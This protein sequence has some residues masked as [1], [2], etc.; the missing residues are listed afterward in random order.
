MATSGQNSTTELDDID[1][2]NQ[3]KRLALVQIK[4]AYQLAEQ[5]LLSGEPVDLILLDCP[6]FLGRDMAP[7]KDAPEHTE[8]RKTYDDTLAVI[9]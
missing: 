2:V 1:F 8:Y 3:S 5:R 7:L 9:Y 4:Q 6:L